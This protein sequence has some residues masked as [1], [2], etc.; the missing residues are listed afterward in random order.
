[1]NQSKLAGM[2]HRKSR[3]SAFVVDVI[4]LHQSSLGFLYIQAHLFYFR[5]FNI[6]VHIT[7]RKGALCLTTELNLQM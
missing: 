1:M 3:A 5:I 4:N 7:Y 2:R 6:V